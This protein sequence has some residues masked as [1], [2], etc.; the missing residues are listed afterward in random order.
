M[1]VEV[2]GIMRGIKYKEV[3]RNKCKVLYLGLGMSCTN[4]GC[5]RFD[6]I[7][8]IWNFCLMVL[9]EGKCSMS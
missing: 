8:N 9:V 6:L 4:I 3:N 5:G 7:L 1:L 2:F